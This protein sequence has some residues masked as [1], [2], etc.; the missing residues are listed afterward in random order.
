MWIKLCGVTD[1]ESARV[2]ADARPDAVGLNFYSKS[3]RHVT[4]AAAR[5][6]VE[7]LPETIAPVGLFVN[8]PI[9]QIASVCA[10]TGIRHVQ[11]HGDETVGDL[12]ELHALAAELQIIRAFRVGDGGLQPVAE[13][14]QDCRT[15]SMPLFACLLDARVAGRYGGTGHVAPWELIRDEYRFDDWPPLI[16]A[17]GLTPDNV[18]EAI[19]TVQPWGVDAAGGVETVPAVKDAELSRRFVQMART[20]PS[21]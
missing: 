16:L 9:E 12:E 20:E 13:F 11:L 18:A 17:G 3:P 6:I 21:D 5:E 1:R 19:R 7:D 8:H 4:P 2:A 10:E 14:V 15:Q